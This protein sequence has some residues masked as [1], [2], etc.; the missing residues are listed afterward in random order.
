MLNA[1]VRGALR[2]RGL[3]MLGAVLLA[4]F[5]I[6]TASRGQ[7]GVFPEF[8]P[9]MVT[10]QT[11]APGLSPEEV[12]Q[13]VT[14]PLERALSGVPGLT[15]QRSQSIQG[16]SALD[17]TFADGTDIHL[18]RQQVAERVA[19]VAG[20][21]PQGVG[22]PTLAPLASSTAYVYA[23]GLTSASRTPMELRAY[24][25]WTLKPKLLGI[26]GIANVTPYGGEVRQL[27]VQLIP[28]RMQARG[29][30]LDQVRQAVA[31][32]TGVRGA[33]F[34]DTPEQRIVLRSDGQSLNPASLAQVAVAAKD[35]AIL[36]LGDVAQVSWAPA[37]PTSIAM[38]DGEPGLTCE[39]F[40]QPGADIMAATRRIEATLD[41]ARPEMDKRGIALH[42]PTFRVASF[43][44]TAVGNA[45]NALMLGGLLVA[46]V[47]FAFL[48]DPR[49]AFISLTAIPLSLLTAVIVLVHMGFTLNTL[50]LGGLTIA[51][52]EV[53]DDAI[54]DV[55]NILRRLRHARAEGA[56]KSAMT[57][58]LSAS[59]EVRGSVVFATG[60]V[61]LIMLP[62]LTFSGVQ[63]RIF[64]PL[65]WAYLSAVLA[66]LLVALTV[67]PAMTLLIFG[68]GELPHEEPAWV[69]GLK[70]RYHAFL[71]QTMA[72]PKALFLGAGILA[73][74]ALVTLPF[75]NSGFLPDFREGHL[76]LQMNL[77]TGASLQESLR[78]GERVAAVLS[79]VDGVARISQRAGRT[80]GGD[81]TVG[82]QFSEFDLELKPGADAETPGR[83]REALQDIP[84]ATFE[85]K[86][87]LADRVDDY[88]SGSAAPVVVQLQG[89]DLDALDAAAARV[90]A[91]LAAVPGAQD[92]A[93]DSPPGQPEWSLRVKP[94]AAARYGL[95][96]MEVLDAIQTAFQGEVVGQIFE[97]PRVTDVALTLAP[98]AKR[99]P[100]RLGA[101]PIQTPDG[102]SLPLSQV[103]EVT[104]GDGRYAVLHDEGQRRSVVTCSVAGRS[105]ASFVK[106]AES[107]VRA[108]AGLH[109][110]I[111]AAFGGVLEAQTAAHR[112]LAF[113]L[114][115]A[116]A[117]ILALLSL[118]FHS[119]RNL[120]LVL[121]NLPFA[122]VGGLL[123]AF[124]TGGTLNLGALVGFVTLFGI[125]MRN[126]IML[127]S[128]AEHLV[129]QEGCAWGEA[130]A[131]RAAEERLI[132]ILMTAMVTALA[133]LP[134]A[135][136]SRAPGREI[137]G[138]M[139]IVIL[140]GLLTSTLLNLLVL[141]TLLQ[142][143]GRFN[144]PKGS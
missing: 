77:P 54:I 132:P 3:V 101:L 104:K 21:L 100:S 111:T 28:G 130:T 105:L 85:V 95:R 36:R 14:L 46:L 26:P 72:R 75:L 62:V 87:Y 143:F 139:A 82:P 52:G 5:G 20:H 76:I 50:T 65:G 80:E 103:V 47:L 42:A 43:I 51:L 67:T 48:R 86:T 44:E 118:V 116:F 69:R 18:A 7:L 131:R 30:S 25:D 94:E 56:P 81:D 49:T 109:P 57:I 140:G 78:T 137:E 29:L 114:L 41:E 96:P 19:E 61:A 83:V 38:V 110:G 24:L 17:A 27:Q 73:A 55:E 35:G 13:L 93:I 10:V 102:R 134:L 15:H 60:V 53:V 70:A 79:K 92:V 124:L 112:E 74:A 107:A 133:L 39:L 32:A 11:Q 58:V 6:Y 88:V 12:E 45:R 16:V 9:P 113:H 90:K 89:D 120:L 108:K 125:T 8:A 119:T 123:A 4:P 106:D 23:F 22:S 135:L 99:D 33:G 128:H 121:A 84:G 117:G 141:P 127:V 136:G 115:L 129:H 1:I 142:R 64:A 37:P 68:R 144:A 63:G 97:G 98:D 31:A 71:D 138:P 91:T 122:L 66:S 34:L 2:L 40:V 59:M 126:S